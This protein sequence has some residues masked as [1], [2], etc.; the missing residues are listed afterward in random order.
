MD[1][2]LTYQIL[3][4]RMLGYRDYENIKVV[5]NGEPM[6]PIQK[7]INLS[8]SIIRADA[9]PITG[10]KTYVREG[11]MQRLAQAAGTLAVWKPEMSLDVGYG[12]RS[13]SV[14]R[15]RFKTVYT[16]L[17]SK[18]S[19]ERLRAAAHRQVAIPE[20]AGHPAGAAVDI[21][22][23]KEGR[24][25]D[26]GTKLWDFRRASYTF[27]PEISNNARKNRWILRTVMLDAGF[28]PFDGEWWHFS[29]GDKEWA[30]YYSRPNAI[31][32][33]IEFDASDGT[34]DV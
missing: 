27:S 6:V 30:K 10:D 15:A 26:L 11:V 1:I 19:G 16:A 24:E 25:I 7:N 8:T 13:L 12:Y 21:Q 33:Q 32:D 29:Y 31:Y 4:A 22:L 17:S 2:D 14:Q 34:S 20:V 18:Y 28:A 5:E 9:V 3:E 23:L